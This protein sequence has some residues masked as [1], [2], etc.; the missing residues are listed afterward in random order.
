MSLEYESGHVGSPIYQTRPTA[1]PDYASAFMISSLDIEDIRMTQALKDDEDDETR[2]LPVAITASREGERVI[3]TRETH[4][5]QPSGGG[6]K[7]GLSML[8]CP[9]SI[10]S[11]SRRM[12]C[13]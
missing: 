13:R 12:F 11:V 4:V 5:C 3:S 9:C 7:I 2:G 8:T 6:N 1:E 10:G